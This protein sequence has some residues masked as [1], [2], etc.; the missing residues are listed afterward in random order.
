MVNELI[1]QPLP[2]ISDSD[3]ARRLREVSTERQQLTE[4]RA[5]GRVSEARARL[6]QLRDEHATLR[7]EACRRDTERLETIVQ[8]ATELA[9]RNEGQRESDRMGKSRDAGQAENNRHSR[10]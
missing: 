7:K 6:A 4:S 2:T 9:I 5:A 3:A 10:G 1:P 8:L